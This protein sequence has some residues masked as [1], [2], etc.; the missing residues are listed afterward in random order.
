MFEDLDGDGTEDH[1]DEDE[2]GDGFSNIIEL[3]YPSDPRDPN[4]V[5][6][7]APVSVSFVD[8]NATLYKFSQCHYDLAVDGSR[9]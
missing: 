2:D 5:A 7:T 8:G 9:L 3:A 6:N 1:L 4:S